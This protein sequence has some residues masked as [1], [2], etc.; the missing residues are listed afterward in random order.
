M[1]NFFQNLKNE[2]DFFIRRRAK[3]SRRNFCPPNEPKEEIF[4]KDLFEKY[5]LEDF[6]NNSTRQNYLENLY[7]LDLFDKY[8]KVE[9]K[10]EIRV[11]DIGCKN[12]SICK[13][14]Y[15]FFKKHCKKVILRGIELDSNRLYNN[16]YSRFEVAKYYTKGIEADYIEGDFLQYEE[17]YD[18]M[19]WVLPFV[20]ERPLLKWGLPQKYFKPEEMLSHALEHLNDGGKI[21]IIN[22]GEEEFE[23]QK[24]LC[25]KLNIKYNSYGQIQSEFLQ[26]KHK[27]FLIEVL[28]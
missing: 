27:M 6:K 28:K 15:F 11:L 16:F 3:I 26:Y 14:E 7:L 12:W 2:I 25:E 19:I 5:G 18:Y 17:K 23:A 20:F 24:R 4:D 1:S 21:F 8:L 10:P 22:Q 9:F 13:A